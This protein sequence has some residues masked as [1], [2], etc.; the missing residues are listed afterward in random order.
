LNDATNHDGAHYVFQVTEDEALAFRR[1][2]IK[3]QN[4]YVRR[5][6]TIGIPLLSFA[7]LLIPIWVANDRGLLPISAVYFADLGFAVGYLGLLIGMRWASRRLY[8]D[9]LGE[10]RSAQVAYDCTFH[11]TGLVVKKGTLESRMTW[12]AISRV[13]DEG[14]IT[15]F[16]YDPTQGFFIPARLFGDAAARSSFAAWATERVRAA[17]PHPLV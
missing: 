12:D 1:L 4:R 3:N 15:A 14:P 6:L 11:D 9:L 7:G 5:S 8:R 2:L 16:W 10:T 17:A 13:H